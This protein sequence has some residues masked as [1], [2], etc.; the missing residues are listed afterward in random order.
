MEWPQ[1][2]QRA[3]VAVER[4]PRWTAIDE[5]GER[6]KMQR[7]DQDERAPRRVGKSVQGVKRAALKMWTARFDHDVKRTA[8]T[9]SRE[10]LLDC[11]TKTD[12]DAK[13]PVARQGRPITIPG[14]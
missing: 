10:R 11:T 3:D 13:L 2:V 1:D 6:L 5:D 7:E 9:A 4:L 8:I 14:E 12:Q